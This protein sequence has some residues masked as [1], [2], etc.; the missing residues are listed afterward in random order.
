MGLGH[1][2]NLPLKGSSPSVRALLSRPL[3]VSLGLNLLDL[4]SGSEAALY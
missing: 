1:F 4:P 3:P 2:L